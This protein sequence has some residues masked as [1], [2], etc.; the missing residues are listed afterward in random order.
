MSHAGEST[1]APCV[2]L[3]RCSRFG[4]LGARTTRHITVKGHWFLTMSGRPVGRVVPA[5]VHRFKSAPVRRGV[6]GLSDRRQEAAMQRETIRRGEEFGFD[7]DR[8]RVWQA[9]GRVVPHAPAPG[10]TEIVFVRD[11]AAGVSEDAREASPARLLTWRSGRRL[12]PSRNWRHC[13]AAPAQGLLP[14]LAGRPAVSQHRGG[15]PWVPAAYAEGRPWARVLR[16][17]RVLIYS[18]RIPHDKVTTWRRPI[19][20]PCQVAIIVG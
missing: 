18:P 4:L 9:G 19:K 2:G 11:F 12:V 17:P 16:V 15:D 20:V 7:E 13:G 8:V 3:L 6:T 14:R 1:D 10:V 5:A